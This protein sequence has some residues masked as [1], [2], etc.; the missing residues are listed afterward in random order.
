MHQFLDASKVLISNLT[1]T[2]IRHEIQ[3]PFANEEKLR[4]VLMQESADKDIRIITPEP[5]LYSGMVEGF[6][7]VEVSISR[8]VDIPSWKTKGHEKSIPIAGRN[9]LQ[10][11]FLD[12]VCFT[13]RTLEEVA[14]K[15]SIDLAVFELVGKHAQNKIQKLGIPVKYSSNVGEYAGLWHVDDLVQRVQMDGERI[16]ASD[17]VRDFFSRLVECKNEE[18]F[19]AKLKELKIREVQTSPSLFLELARPDSYLAKSF[20][21]EAVFEAKPLIEKMESSYTAKER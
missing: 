6:P 18:E 7:V 19:R 8:K 1:H 13:G 17:F 15:C 10:N 2:N 4:A 20:K 11:I 21:K 12:S 16:S 14:K 3:D 9:G 5:K